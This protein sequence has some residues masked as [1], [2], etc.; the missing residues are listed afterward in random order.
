ML[1]DRAFQRILPMNEKE[2]CPYEDVLT[3]VNGEILYF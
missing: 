1:F 3:L 2:F